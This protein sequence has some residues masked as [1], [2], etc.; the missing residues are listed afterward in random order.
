[1]I[2]G[3]LVLLMAGSGVG[4]L[5]VNFDAPTPCKPKPGQAE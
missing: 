3:R 5:P 4:S 2:A 1:M